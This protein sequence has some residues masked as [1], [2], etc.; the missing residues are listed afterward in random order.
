VRR[1]ALVLGLFLLLPASASAQQSGPPDAARRAAMEARRDSLEAE[2]LQ[3]FVVQLTRELKLD[4]DQRGRV[5]RILRASSMRYRELMRQAGDLRGKMYRATRNSATTDAEF[6][7]LVAEHEAL[8]VRESDMWRRDQDMLSRIL[9]PR[10]RV[11]FLVQ[12]AHFQENVR[13]ILERQGRGGDRR[14]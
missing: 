3:K 11:Q 7:Q 8:R 9:N 1:V 10:Q 5:E 13:D 4:A 12:W 6:A 2:I 14:Q